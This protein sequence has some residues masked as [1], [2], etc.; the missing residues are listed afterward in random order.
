[1]PITKPVQPTRRHIE[2]TELKHWAKRWNVTDEQL[3]LA[4]GKVG[5]SV[6]AVRKELAVDEDPKPIAAL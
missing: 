4:I 6:A 3:R 5:N 2:Q 1:M